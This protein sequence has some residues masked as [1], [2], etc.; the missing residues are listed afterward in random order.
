VCLGISSQF[1][2]SR[3]SQLPLQQSWKVISGIVEGL[4][5]QGTISSFDLSKFCPTFPCAALH[6]SLSDIFTSSISLTGCTHCSESIRYHR[7]P[8]LRYTQS[9][10]QE[11]PAQSQVLQRLLQLTPIAQGHWYNQYLERP[12]RMTQGSYQTRTFRYWRSEASYRSI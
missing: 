3:P 1:Q 6:Y 7:V 5:R 2:A 10:F 4:C 9:S 8:H 11:S 12:S